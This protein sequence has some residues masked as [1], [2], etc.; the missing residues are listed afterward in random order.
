VIEDRREE[1]RPPSP[2]VQAIQHGKPSGS[3]NLVGGF[4]LPL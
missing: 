4:N 3:P 2:R 1:R